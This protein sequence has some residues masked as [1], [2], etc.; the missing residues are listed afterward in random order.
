[1]WLL[2]ESALALNG[3]L[4]G[5]DVLDSR[6][7]TIQLLLWS[8]GEE[9]GGVLPRIFPTQKAMC[10]NLVQALYQSRV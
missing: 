8:P 7:S 6:S 9:V 2:L 3:K 5:H 4:S 10:A 1:V